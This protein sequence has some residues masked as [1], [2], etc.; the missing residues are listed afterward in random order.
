MIDVAII[1]GGP[2]GLSAAINA[3]Q[4]NK[5]A[6][7]IGKDRSTSIIYEAENVDNYLGMSNYSGKKMMD[8]FYEHARKK[9]VQF[10]DGTVLQIFP[11][12]KMCTLNVENKLIEARTVILATGQGKNKTIKNE[13]NLLG[14]GVSYC[15][16]CDG[17]LY[18][19]KKVVVISE[20]SE[21]EEEAQ[22]L[23]QICSKVTYIPLYI[24]IGVMSERIQIVKETPLAVLGE[25]QVTGL[26]T[27]KGVYD[28]QGV[29]FIKE[30]APID[31][32]LPGIRLVDNAIAVDRHMQT[33]IKNVF[34]AGD[35]TG[36]PYQVSKAVG[37][38]QIAAWKA[39]KLIEAERR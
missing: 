2:A 33:N 14:K 34:A 10:M 16:T 25:E 26:K 4:R 23:A 28:C 17:M 39:V 20:I 38:G 32:I 35:C 27:N 31:T 22:F 13:Q 21:G 30:T 9:G 3:V 7:V 36:R 6:C 24:P 18:K 1:G 19:N 37:E 8:A 12:E 29:F 11:S 5:T 15:A